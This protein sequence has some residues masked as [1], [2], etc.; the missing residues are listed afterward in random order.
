MVANL[1]LI[2]GRQQV[3]PLTNKS[4][5][6]RAEGEVVVVEETTDDAFTT[7]TA[8]GKKEVLGVVAE[9]IADN[10]EGRVI[11][12]GYVP[13]LEVD[14]AT[15]RGDFLKTSTTAGKAT[16]A[17]N[18]EAGSFAIALSV[19]VGAGQVSAFVFAGPFGGTAAH[20]VE[21]IDGDEIDG[22]KLDIDFT[23]SEYTPDASPAE[24][25]DVDDLTAHLKGIDTALSQEVWQTPDLLNDWVNFGGAKETAQ[26]FK[27][28]LGIVHLKGFVKDGT[29]GAVP[30]F[31]LPAG[32]RPAEEM[33]V[34][35]ISN[36]AI[37]RCDI[38]LTGQVR[39][40]AGNN[41]WFSL[42]G[43]TFRAA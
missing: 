11:C 39:A 24:A 33:I 34:V 40:Q 42:T 19:A 8:E 32:Y 3:I 26:Y 15:V 7:T 20:A 4:G 6:E 31:T 30:I 2:R 37:A 41:A 29:I 21:H 9:T 28:T 18:P 12:S 35:T 17:T 10:A 38:Q 25:D 36:D 22:D 13:V 14:G 27:D 23:P 16:P 5:A 43:I 1:N